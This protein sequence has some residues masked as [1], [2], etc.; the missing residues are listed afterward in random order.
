[1]CFPDEMIVKMIDLHLDPTTE[2]D[3]WKMMAGPKSVGA[4]IGF[5]DNYICLYVKRNLHI[6]YVDGVFI[7]YGNNKYSIQFYYFVC[8]FILP[9]K[10]VVRQGK[11]KVNH[12]NR[13]ARYTR[14]LFLVLIHICITQC[15]YVCIIFYITHMYAYKIRDN[16]KI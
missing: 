7:R 14:E 8:D 9:D 16:T 11:H 4:N 3:H 6:L 1:M 5:P 2:D 13:I 15:I 12:Y 10:K